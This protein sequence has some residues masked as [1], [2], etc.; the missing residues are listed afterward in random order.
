VQPWRR[1]CWGFLPRAVDTGLDSLDRTNRRLG[2]RSFAGR[3]PQPSD[4]EASDNVA[5][6]ADD[7]ANIAVPLGAG[8]AVPGVSTSTMLVSSRDRHLLSV[9]WFISS[10]ATLLHSSATADGLV[11]FY[12]SDQMDTTGSG[13]LECFS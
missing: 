13:M 12:L 11:G 8:Q 2:K 10:G 4:G 6:D 5:I 1:R 9:V 3:A 7:W